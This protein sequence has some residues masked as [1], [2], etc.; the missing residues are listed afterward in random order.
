MSARTHMTKD[1]TW[2]RRVGANARR[3]RQERGIVQIDVVIAVRAQGVPLGEGPLSKLE[4]G[5]GNGAVTVD[6][7][8]A[9]ADALSV[10]PMDLLAP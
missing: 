9:L 7:L 8:M 4:R 10:S 5:V 2:S 1:L 3:I 6:L